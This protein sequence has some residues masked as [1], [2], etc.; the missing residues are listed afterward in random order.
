MKKVAAAT[1]SVKLIQ[2]KN[3]GAS[4]VNILNSIGV[5]TYEDLAHLGSVQSYRRI[6]QRGI[7]VSRAM[8]YAMEAALLDVPWQSLD[9]AL[10]AQ[11][12]QTAERID[13]EENE[14]DACLVIDKQKKNP[15]R[16]GRI[17][18]KP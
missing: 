17:S 3:L 8:L 16:S 11:L 4:S 18:H 6:R 7:H 9:P 13:R 15:E 14:A 2:M 5:K 1:G 10:K 12:V